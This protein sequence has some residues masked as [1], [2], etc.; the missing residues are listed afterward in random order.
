MVPS[1]KSIHMPV[2]ATQAFVSTSQLLDFL[3]AS[4]VLE[5]SYFAV[6]WKRVVPSN[7]RP[8]I[9]TRKKE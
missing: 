8:E 5:S 9:M 6:L 1:L 2:S 7:V 4:T 3:R